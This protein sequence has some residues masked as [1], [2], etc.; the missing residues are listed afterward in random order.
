MTLICHIV[1]EWADLNILPGTQWILKI[2]VLSIEK[3]D[4]SLTELLPSG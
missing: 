1:G 2:S 3:G 4:I